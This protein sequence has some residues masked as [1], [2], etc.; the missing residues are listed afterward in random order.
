MTR[1]K[2]RVSLVGLPPGEFPTPIFDVVIDQSR[3][4]VPKV[5]EFAFRF[6]NL[7]SSS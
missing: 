6:R 1:R 4:N 5:S 2:G 7:S 3:P